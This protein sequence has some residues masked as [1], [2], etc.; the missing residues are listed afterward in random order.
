M[1]PTRNITVYCSSS[2]RVDAI[3]PQAAAELGAAI[4]RAG[5][6]LVYGGNR[7][8]VMGTLADAARA[9]GGR[10]VGITPQL[11]L[12]K[13]M[14]DD[15]CH[16]L[17]IA[18]CMRHRKGLMETRGDAFIAMPGGLGT[19]EE[20][21]EIIVGRQLGYHAKP[22]VLINIDD[23]FAPMLAM[24]D[25]GIEKSF[26]KPKARDAFRVTAS[27]DEAIDHLRR[28]FGETTATEPAVAGIP[29][30]AGNTR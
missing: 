17:V 27:V 25:H 2:T 12:D 3:Y 18:D 30:V 15:F 9:A 7:V 1:I 6:G 24:I 22:I 13:G 28:A 16:E 11:F 20:I 23:Y 14:G 26:I 21:F 5:W 4:A 8:G 10:V 19:F 29:V